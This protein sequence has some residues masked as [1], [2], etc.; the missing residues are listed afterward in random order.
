MARAG[1]GGTLDLQSP[2]PVILFHELS[3]AFRIVQN[4]LNALTAGCNPSSP[5][6][7]A[8]IVDENDLRTQIANA[9]GTA[10]VLRDPGIHCASVCTGGS[11][12]SCCIVASVASGSP[13]SEEVATLRAVRD[14]FVRKSDIGFA[15]FDTLH[16]DYY[17]FS[18]Q[19]CT[20]MA[21]HPALRLLVL[22]GFVRPLVTMLSVIQEFA[23]KS[24]AASRLG[25]RF[26]ADHVDR[27][28]SAA[29]LATLQQAHEVLGG[30]EAGL[31]PEHRELSELLAPALTSEH[32]LWA[33]IEPVQLYA[34]ALSAS[35][36]ECP[37][38][39]LGEQ[40]YQEIA[41]WALRMPLDD[42]WGSLTTVEVNDELA[43]LERTL[44]RTPETRAAF[45]RRLKSKQG[46]ATAIA[47]LDDSRPMRGARG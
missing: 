6:E 32:L 19:V 11:S 36:D 35:L 42:V 25:V 44:L 10:P 38:E 30:N 47:N 22:E 18:P 39:E 43:Q 2:N 12:G 31:P 46:R 41:S 1:T 9:S 29:R 3:H 34:S 21:R 23:L 45:R 28:A 33:V 17:A 20:L 27:A 37:A 5:E 26:A 8:A 14:G 15:F 4:T 16:R 24:A 13:L 7:N 40:L